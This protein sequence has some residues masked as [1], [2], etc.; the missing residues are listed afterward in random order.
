MEDGPK[1]V[2][3]RHVFSGPLAGCRLWVAALVCATLATPASAQAEFFGTMACVLLLAGPVV[4]VAAIASGAAQSVAAPVAA[5]L[6]RGFAWGWRGWHLPRVSS[7]DTAP[8]AQVI[9]RRLSSGVSY[10]SS[11]APSE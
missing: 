7:A 2:A 8:S 9:S 1:K 3:G 5:A 4:L 6:E 10:R 11:S